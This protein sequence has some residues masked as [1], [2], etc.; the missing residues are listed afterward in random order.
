MLLRMKG[1]AVDEDVVTEE[2]VEEG[3]VVVM[4]DAVVMEAVVAMVAGEI[5]DAVVVVQP[6]DPAKSTP[7]TR[8]HSL[9]LVKYMAVPFCSLLYQALRVR[10]IGLVGSVGKLKEYIN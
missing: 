1:D 10:F 2:V 6:Q 8:H 4:E 9:H 3:A 5:E 7:W